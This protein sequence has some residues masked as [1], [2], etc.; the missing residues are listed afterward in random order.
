[1]DL[2]TDEKLFFRR[3]FAKV[4]ILL[5]HICVQRKR[6]RES[7]RFAIVDIMQTRKSFVV[8]DLQREKRK[9]LWVWICKQRKNSEK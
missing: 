9:P 1:M 5:S 2:Q 6:N 3:K 8:V 7:D 4:K